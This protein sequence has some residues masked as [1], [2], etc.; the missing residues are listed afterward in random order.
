MWRFTLTAIVLAGVVL[1]VCARQAMGEKDLLVYWSAARLLA[2][3]GNPY[4]SAALAAVQRTAR[5]G[6]EDTLAAWNPPWLLVLLLPLGLLPFDVARCMWLLANSVLIGMAA[7]LSWRMLV[8]TRD[9]GVMLALVAGLWFGESLATM[10]MGQI[11][12]LLLI[13][14]VLGSRWLA[15]NDDRWAGAAFFLT[16][17]KPHIT[18]LLLLLLVLWAAHERRWRV[19]QGLAAAG[20]FGVLVLFAL[21]AGWAWSYLQLTG[22]HAFFQ[23]STSTLGGLAYALW[24]TDALRF[25]GLLTIPLLPFL[26]R[27]ALSHGFLT[28]ANVTLLIS[29]PLAVYGFGFDHVVL[30][31]AI[32]QMLSWIWRRQLSGSWAL[33][34]GSGLVLVYLVLFAQLV[35]PRILYHW[36]AWTPVALG[37]LYALAW[38]RRADSAGQSAARGQLSLE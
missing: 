35:Q 4:D 5:A 27:L 17:V 18:Y 6:V 16:T 24:G 29:V 3:G 21:R 36:R 7:L 30:V 31:P 12:S 23:Y 34:V 37:L 9:W 15:S 19:F 2:T 32:V 14:L 38:T 11:S 28:A 25:A 33:L 22:S 10:Q 1:V 13:G 8:Q 20:L 26:L